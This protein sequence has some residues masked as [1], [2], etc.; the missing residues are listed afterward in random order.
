M[1]KLLQ[2]QEPRFR[3]TCPF[4]YILCMEMEIYAEM[5]ALLS[6]RRRSYSIFRQKFNFDGTKKK[7]IGN[8]RRQYSIV[9]VELF[10]ILIYR[11]SE[12][13]H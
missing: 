7:G 10:E 13:S 11:A 9:D 5:G 1:E 6:F 2:V 4:V 8:Q 3:K 12:L